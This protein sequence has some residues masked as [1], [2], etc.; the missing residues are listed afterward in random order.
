MHKTPRRLTRT[1]ALLIGVGI[2]GACSATAEPKAEIEANTPV[3]GDT[4]LD[5]AMKRWA[6]VR[7][8]SYEFTVSQQC[9]CPQEIRNPVV[10]W[11]RGDSIEART[12]AGSGAALDPARAPMP[13]TVDGLFTKI[14]DARARSAAAINVTYHATLGSPTQ[15]WIDYAASMADEELG[16]E[17]RDLRAR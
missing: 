10:V 17:A 13:I 11:V 8:A 6:A 12:Y 7:P 14:R 15:L 16:F 2:A 9:F 1:L 5:A 4:A 3:T